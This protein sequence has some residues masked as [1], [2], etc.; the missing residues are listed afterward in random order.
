MLLRDIRIDYLVNHPKTLPIIAQLLFEAWPYHSPN[1]LADGMAINLQG[2]MHRDRLPLALVAFER[3]QP[4]GTVSLKI[5]EVETHRQYEHWLGDLFVAEPY[6][7]QGV[8]SRLIEA[9]KHEAS[10]LGIHEL[11]LYTRHADTERLYKKLGWV[12]VERPE[13]RARPAVIMKTA[14]NS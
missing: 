12:E 13:Y 7:Q 2:R 5:R 1:G 10:K 9:A 6:R 3:E 4:I 8:G 11:Y 14:T